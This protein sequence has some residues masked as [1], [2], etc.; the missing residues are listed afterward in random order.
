MSAEKPS[1]GYGTIW[2]FLMVLL[3]L[4]VACLKLPHGIA[5]YLI[6]AVAVVKAFLVLRHYMHVHGVPS[7]IYALIGIPVVLAGILIYIV[8]D[9]TLDPR[10]APP[11]PPAMEAHE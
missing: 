8:A 10:K 4:G 6:F 2:I 7:M 1:I 5:V 3:V 9:A 11:P